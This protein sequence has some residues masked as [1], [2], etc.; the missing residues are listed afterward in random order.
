VPGEPAQPGRPIGQALS[1]QD[2]HHKIAQRGH[3]LWRST[4][5]NST[6]VLAERDVADVVELVFNGPVP[7][8][9]AEQVCWPGSLR[10]QAGDLVM[11]FGMPATTALGL[12]HQPA[13]LTQARPLQVALMLTHGASMK[14]PHIDAAV[15]TVNS[16]RPTFGWERRERSGAPP[17]ARPPGSP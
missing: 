13:D 3:G 5:P 11:H 6:G 1:L 14:R 4:G 9:E 7:A 10:G 2:G 17:G 16:S 15:T 8:V 12:M